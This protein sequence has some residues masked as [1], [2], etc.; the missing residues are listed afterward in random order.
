MSTVGFTGGILGSAAGAPLSQTSGPTAE[1]AQR[2]SAAV[3]RQVE[4]DSKAEQ[5]AGIGQ[6]EEDAQAD[7][8]DADGRRLWEKAPHSGDQEHEGDQVRG[9]RGAPDATGTAGNALDLV[10]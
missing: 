8:R 7:E 10:G 2:E 5:A 1:R 4:A 3:T 9:T 6:T